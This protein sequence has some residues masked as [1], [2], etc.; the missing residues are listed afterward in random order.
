M[1][2][3][4]PYTNFHDIN[5]DYILNRLK[6]IEE[7]VTKVSDISAQWED[8][9]IQITSDLDTLEAMYQK[10]LN[11]NEVFKNNIY[12]SFAVLN[13]DINNKFNNLRSDIDAQFN[14]YIYDSN[15]RINSLSNQ[16]TA[17][18]RKLDDA[19]ANLWLNMTMINPFTGVE[20]GVLNVIDYLASLHMQDGISAGEYDALELT[21]QVYDNKQLTAREYDTQANILLRQ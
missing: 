21:A 1:Y 16:I 11:D 4:Y 12:N 14:Q 5:L 8:T 13:D 7:E 2:R 3:K 6:A 10:M 19:L 9:L 18:N 17:M 20:E 15:L